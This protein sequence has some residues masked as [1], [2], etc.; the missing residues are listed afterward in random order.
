MTLDLKD[1]GVAVYMVV[2]MVVLFGGS[3]IAYRKDKQNGYIADSDE[4][5]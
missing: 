4:Q 5:E 1:I 3:F 2:V